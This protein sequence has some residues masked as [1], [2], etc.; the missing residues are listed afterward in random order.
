MYSFN[1]NCCLA[2]GVKPAAR[3]P[4]AARRLVKC[5]PAIIGLNAPLYDPREDLD[6]NE[7]FENAVFK[8]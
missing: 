8:I 5:G 3:R 4:H 2:S 6:M 7:N 1:F